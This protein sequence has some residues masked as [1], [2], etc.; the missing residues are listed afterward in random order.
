ML[1]AGYLYDAGLARWERTADMRLGRRSQMCGVI[2][3]GVGQ[4]VGD[5]SS[6]NLKRN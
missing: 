1:N 3:N 6:S 2:E 5:L 4:K